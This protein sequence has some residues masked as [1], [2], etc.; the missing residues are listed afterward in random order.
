MGHSIFV[1][2]NC[3][4]S[5]CRTT[6]NRS[7][8]P[9]ADAVVFHMMDND[10]LQYPERLPKRAYPKQ[11]FIFYN[12][13]APIRTDVRLLNAFNDVFNLTMSYRHDADVSAP[14]WMA[15]KTD[16]TTNLTGI[17]LRN[18][19]RKKRN[20]VWF[21]S[22]CH[23]QGSRRWDY[24]ME[25]RKYIDIDIYGACGNFS[26]PK[27]EGIRCVI[28]AGRTYRFYLAFENAFCKDYLTEKAH[29]AWVG[30]MI[31]VV[32]G[33]YD[34]ALPPKAWLDVSDYASTQNLARKMTFLA[35]NDKEYLSYF[36]FRKTYEI[37]PRVRDKGFCHLCK[38]L[39]DTEYKYKSRF[40]VYRWWVEEGNCLGLHDVS[41][42]LG[43]NPVP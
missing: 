24:V 43:L 38:I 12:F 1:D 10:F 4:V 39:H 41:V 22:A 28:E 37:R 20:A 30:N 42:R 17:T 26:C 7:E 31:P 36:D 3:P 27:S 13:E 8:F 2:S 16:K 18:V 29:K 35:E 21:V 14:P 40:D 19:R 9:V 23:R 25:L 5:F 32:L 15:H 34:S 33:N 6:A 11:I